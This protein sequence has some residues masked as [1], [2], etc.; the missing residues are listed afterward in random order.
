MTKPIKLA[1][2]LILTACS[3]SLGQSN[4]NYWFQTE[5]SEA[6]NLEKSHRTFLPTSY[7]LVKLNSPEI[8]LQLTSAPLRSSGTTSNKVITFPMANGQL[9]SFKFYEAPVIDSNLTAL[10]PEIRSY[11]GQGIEDPTSIVRF[12]TSAQGIH[13]MITSGLHKT[14][15]IEPYTQNKEY[16]I[17]Y[18][19]EDIPPAQELFEC[20][21]REI[22]KGQIDIPET[23]S[24][25]ADDGMLRTFRLAVVCTGEY[26]QFHLSN[27]GVDPGESDLIKKQAVLSAINTTMTRVNGIFER[28]LALTMVVVADNL[29]I[30]FLDPATDGLTNDSPGALLAQGQQ[31]CD[32]EIL[33]ENYDIGHVFSTEGGGFAQLSSACVS[34]TKAFGVSGITSP[35]GDAF[36]L[37]FVAHEM[38]H[39][40]GGRHMQNNDCQRSLSSMEPGSGSTILS[41]AGRCAPNVQN[42]V[43]DYFN[44]TSIL[45]M[46]NNISS[47]TS[48][49]AALSP[50]NNLPPVADAGDAFFIPH[51]TP[52]ILKGQATDP[53]TENGLTYCWEQ[54]DGEVAVMPPSSESD[55]G[56]MSRSL[57]PTIESD[58]YIPAFSTVLSG[59]NDIW[60]VLP[61][62]ARSMR[63]R[64]TV[65]DNVA[66][67]AASDSNSNLVVTTEDGPFRIF[68]QGVGS[69]WTINTER[70][71][72]WDV[73][74]TNVEP[75]NAF[76]VDILL[77]TDGGQNFDIVLA[78]GT[79]NDG[80]EAITLPNL[81]NSNEARLMIVAN[82]NI[83]YNV[84]T[85][86]FLITDLL[87]AETLNFEDV[88]IW[89]NPSTGDFNISFKTIDE[90]VTIAIYD[91][92]GRKISES[93]ETNPAGS[94]FSK[95]LDYTNLQSGMYFLKINN[96]NYT[97]TRRIVKK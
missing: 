11:S 78:A 19:R 82:N 22:A 84:N 60:E 76:T 55:N 13:A 7:D 54:R 62:V 97:T 9:S 27:Q 73:A 58:R 36:N 79:P 43:D 89:P 3:V 39:Q 10:F 42:N 32:S 2:L 35:I 4:S 83:F 66:N 1:A 96:G 34:G 49:C 71:V 67:G 85:G 18:S 41:Y 69:F 87:S 70:N 46:W 6:E 5:A 37:D 12:S 48:T 50:T 33:D 77:S 90:N 21:L 30:I 94:S 68:T 14:V 59:A 56:P 92:L 28:D 61:S 26:S 88:K 64:L 81:P 45:E 24:R 65:R 93:N 63:F 53:D 29:D 8:E 23:P 16:Y 25:N 51:S 17:V 15:Y 20:N 40:Y 75:V 80:I 95:N 47:V 74:N 91:V 38:G 31:L 52:F 72:I 44:G 57:P 86:N